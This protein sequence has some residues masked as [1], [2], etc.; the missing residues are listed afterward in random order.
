MMRGCFIRI[1]CISA[2]LILNS[3]FLILNS[4][5]A[6]W[7]ETYSEKTG[8]VLSLH[9][10]DSGYELYSPLQTADPIPVSKWS[11]QNDTL[12]LEC[13]SIGFKATLKQQD[14][15]WVGT[16]QQGILKEAV[17]LRPADTLFQLRRPQTPQPP[18]RFDEETVAVDYVDSH[19]DKVHLEG[20]LTYPLGARTA[21][22]A[23]PCLV[24][25]SGSGQQNRNEEIF[26]HKP[27]LVLADY[28][29][30][31]G[32]AVLRYDD[33]GVGASTGS[34][35]SADTYLFAEDAEA[36]FN[37]LKNNPQ[38]DPAHLGIGGHSEG[39]A[40]APIVAARNKE[41]KFVVMLAG[42]GCTG[43]EVLLQQNDAIY[44]INGLSDSLLAIRN[45]CM[46]ELFA[47]PADSPQKDY[48]VI[49]NR[50]T[51]SLSKAQ[52]DS[53][54]L[55]RGAAYTIKQQLANPWMQS[56]LRLDPADYLPGVTCPILA[57]QGAK[58][59]QVVALPNIAAITKLAGQSTHYEIFA[60]LNHLFQH[61]E[62]GSPNEYM[63]IEET[64]APEA[65]KALADWIL[66]L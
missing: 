44:R 66:S 25:V 38:V 1:I 61:C 14:S 37:A 56:F 62:K 4:A 53:L 8:L 50:H 9:Q 7:W 29:A 51:A 28:L 3:S 54:G 34:L 47:L 5:Q 31:R 48:Q 32:I 12:R 41:V 6:Q 21:S 10:T 55:G 63:M 65:M 43:R 26:Q 18:Y 40:I 33:R 2:F 30:S 39:G 46:Q 23:F 64:F 19:G 13:A 52:I 49:I 57:L 16:W 45:A 27:F 22:S 24:L 60:G 58:D 59:C 11:L 15:L 36:M 42:Q 17:T 35:D 20:T